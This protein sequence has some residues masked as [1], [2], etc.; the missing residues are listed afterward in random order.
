[1]ET[2]M[3]HSKNLTINFG[4]N[5]REIR[6]TLNITQEQLSRMAFID[7]GHM[8]HIERGTKSPSL[9]KVEKIARALNITPQA[10]LAMR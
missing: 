3:T 2:G 9:D 8:G 5:V 1:M 4:E 10:L 7:R 6:N